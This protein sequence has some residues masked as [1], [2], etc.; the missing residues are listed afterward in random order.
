MADEF[1]DGTC[2][3]EPQAVVVLEPISYVFK[4]R[5]VLGLGFG[6]NSFG[7]FPVFVSM[8]SRYA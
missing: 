6:N 4:F 7:V 5:K 2:M 1:G 3:S 8:L